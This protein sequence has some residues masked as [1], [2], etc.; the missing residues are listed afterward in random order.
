MRTFLMAVVACALW[1]SGL[2]RAQDCKEAG[3]QAPQNNAVSQGGRLYDNW[4]TVCGL[5]PPGNT[6]PA[7]AATVGKQAGAT[8]WRCKEC[9]GWDYRG[10]DG[11]YGKGS[12]YTGIKG[13]SAYAGRDEASIVALLKNETHQYG[14]VLSDGTLYLIAQFVRNG[15]VDASASIDA[16]TKKVVGDPAFGKRI[17]EDQCMACHGV[18][19]RAINFSDKPA[20]PEY[21]GTIASD[22]PWEMLHKIRNGQPGAVMDEQ[23]MRQSAND[24]DRRGGSHRG[25]GMGM[26]MLQGRAMPAQGPL[27]SL[28]EQLDLLSYLQT[29]PSR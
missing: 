26:H 2:A 18:R 7:Y 29:L 13:I 15:Q 19:G 12:H 16:A 6:H 20:E 14:K 10:K 25:M 9:H 22:N 27:L 17:F 3:W 1:A 4:W 21:V 5:T 23:H 24:P 11:A 28:K 8:T